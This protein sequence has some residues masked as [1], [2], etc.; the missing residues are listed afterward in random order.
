[1]RFLL[2]LLLACQAVFGQE[3]ELARVMEDQAGEEDVKEVEEDIQQLRT[4]NLRPL[5]LNIAIAEDLAV[6]PFLNALHIEQL[7][8][9][10]KFTG[11]LIDV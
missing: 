2:L 11:K 9:Y 3:E 8:Q 1:M 5:N 6:F 7:L 10:R 4:F